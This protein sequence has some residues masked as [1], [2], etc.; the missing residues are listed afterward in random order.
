M[1]PL[2]GGP[3]VALQTMSQALSDAG[4]HV[5]ICTTNI[6]RK[7][8]LDV[9][10]YQPVQQFGGSTWYFPVTFHPYSISFSLAKWLNANIQ[11]Y[12]IVHLHG[13]F[14]FPTDYAAWL[15][16][17]K[18]IPYIIRPLGILN[19]YGVQKRKKQL[20]KLWL[21]LL[22]PTLQGAKAIHFTSTAE[23]TE[24]QEVIQ[25]INGVI[26][27][28]GI[29]MAEFEQLPTKQAF[30]EQYPQLSEQKILLFLSRIDPKKGLEMLLPAFKNCCQ[31]HQNLHL[32]IAGSGEPTYERSIKNLVSQLDIEHSITFT[33]HV[34][35]NQKLLLFAG[36]DLFVLPSYSENFGVSVIEAM[37]A[38]LPVLI[39]KNVAISNEITSASAGLDFDTSKTLE[40]KIHQFLSQSNRN[41]LS[42]NAR[43]LAHVSFSSKQM[44][45]NL[46]SL[47]SPRD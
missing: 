39:S 35:G 3:T 25:N 26:L 34:S 37:A 13:I 2:H 43:H 31:L 28:L 36:A 21:R 38:G 17:R 11:N 40:E 4:I 18:N 19:Q 8:A 12:S 33:G 27:P 16:K 32:I 29:N 1:S 46:I 30:L 9:P 42:T 15:A 44:A 24:A 45:N 14:T 41:K 5:D 6:S 20:K 22:T 10:L 7:S 47:Y 23:K